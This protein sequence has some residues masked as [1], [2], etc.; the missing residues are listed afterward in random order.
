MTCA[1]LLV[2]P[3]CLL[4]NMES[5]GPTSTIGAG[6]VFFTSVVVSVHGVMDPELT[7]G[8]E[9]Q[10]VAFQL[11]AFQSIS[12][13]CFATMCHF[14]VVP[15]TATLRPYFPALPGSKPGSGVPTKTL[16]TL[17]CCVM[18][19]CNLLYIPVGILGYRAF[20]SE[21]Q[22]NVLSNFGTHPKHSTHFIA[23][24]ID[25]TI[26]RA[27]MALCTC[28]S[29][30]IFTYITRMAIADVLQGPTRTVSSPGGTPPN[31]ADLEGASL[32]GELSTARHFTITVVFLFT[33]LFASIGVV[34]ADISLGF[35]VSIIG[36][37][38]RTALLATVYPGCL[39]RLDGTRLRIRYVQVV[40]A[41]EFFFPAAMCW[42]LG[43]PIPTVLLTVVGMTILILGLF[44]TLADEVMLCTML[45]L[46][47]AGLTS[48]SITCDVMHVAGVR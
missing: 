47:V 15:A 30:P 44:V 25:I 42:K 9:Y 18:L 14:T 36:A 10:A 41:V 46:I 37:T 8:H 4:R 19:W 13:V 26:A 32:A 48:R 28:L 22:S 5:L 6:C 7:P 1:T 20:G 43:R 35:T 17:C 12:I 3:L 11:T 45:P 40:V 16:V 38:V 33:C 34:Y 29:Y 21:V 31:V 2:L 39:S 24:T 27:C 23:Q